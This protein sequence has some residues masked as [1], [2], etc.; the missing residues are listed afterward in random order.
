MLVTYQKGQ[1]GL[2]SLDI[3]NVKKAKPEDLLL[4]HRYMFSDGTC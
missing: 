2:I 3:L 4:L 1:I